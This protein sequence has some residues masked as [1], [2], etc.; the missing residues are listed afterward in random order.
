M[1]LK[2]GSTVS[3]HH[4]IHLL[5]LLSTWVGRRMQRDVGQ[6]VRVVESLTGPWYRIGRNVDASNLFSS[7]D[8]A[9]ELPSMEWC[10]STY[11][12]AI[13]LTFLKR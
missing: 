12:V 6:V 5:Q 1:G 9:E 3:L 7:I 2:F 8:L 10:T 4:S 13:N 11:F